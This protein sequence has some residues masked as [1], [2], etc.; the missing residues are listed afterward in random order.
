MLKTGQVAK[1]AGVCPRTIMDWADKGILK[2]WRIP[3]RRRERRFDP[4][5]V[6]AFFKENGIPVPKALEAA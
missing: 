4:K 6:L 3:A 2:C 1:L 5:V